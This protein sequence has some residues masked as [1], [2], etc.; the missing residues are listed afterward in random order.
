MRTILLIVG[1]VLILAAVIMF[2]LSG[3]NYMMHRSTNDA[4]NEFYHK[5][6]T[7]FEVF[8]NC[9]IAVFAVGVIVVIVHFFI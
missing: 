8:R 2:A 3:L 5:V 1:I 9:G 4:P 7:R 6:Y